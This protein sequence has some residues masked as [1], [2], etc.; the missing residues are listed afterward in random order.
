MQ[1][2]IESLRRQL[3]REAEERA[4]RLTNASRAAARRIAER[5]RQA[6][7]EQIAEYVNH[8]VTLEGVGR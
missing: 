4:S 2:D 5:F 6:S 1:L 7:D 8:M 3:V